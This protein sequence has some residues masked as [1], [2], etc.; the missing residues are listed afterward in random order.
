M[1][2]STNL[3][4]LQ[5]ALESTPGTPPGGSWVALPF[6]GST[7][8]GATPETAISDT[9]RADRQVVDLIK[10]NESVG[11]SFDFELI[12]SGIALGTLIQGAMQET[13]AAGASL[14]TAPT[15]VTVVGSVITSTGA[16]TASD[17][18]AG[19]WIRIED[20]G[21]YEFFRVASRDSD[22]E[23]TVEGT[24][25]QA[26]LGA[27]TD[28]NIYRGS[29]T[30]NGTTTSTF[31]IERAFT[32]LTTP[33]Y[34]YLS[35]LEVD[36]FS[37]SASSN[38]IVTGSVSFVGRSHNVT[39][40]QLSFTPG[41]PTTAGPFNAAANVA[42]IGEGGTPGL[43]VATDIS[44]EISNNLRERNAIGV[45]GASSIGSG[46]FNVSGNISVYFEDETMLEKLL[47][48][49]ETSLSFGFYK[50]TGAAIIFDVPAIKFTE[51]VPEVSGKNEDVMLNLGWQAYRSAATGY[52][53]KI[54]TFS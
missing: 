9:I 44:L 46:E 34:E 54:I 19:D 42:T 51:G 52:T 17:V 13:T 18:E 7:D 31:T 10:L 35:G 50:S 26:G 20:D 11:G 16:F 21:V 39:T 30:V 33:V 24:P 22:D 27:L 48:N 4:S 6:T 49:T 38:S 36:T 25:A 43:Q 32:D 3:V 12:N 41:S 28:V 29:D 53:L 8:F 2:A 5:L 1:P 23:I 37:V 45:I 14:V 15:S 47:D 40:S